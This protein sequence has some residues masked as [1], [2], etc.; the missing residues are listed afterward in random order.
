MKRQNVDANFWLQMHHTISCS[1]KLHKTKHNRFEWIWKIH[2]I[3]QQKFPIHSTPID[4]IQ[5]LWI[6]SFSSFKH[7]Y[8]RLVH[9]FILIWMKWCHRLNVQLNKEWTWTIQK[10]ICNSGSNIY[11][12]S[13]LPASKLYI[14]SRYYRYY[15]RPCEYFTTTVLL[16]KIV[17]K[18]AKKWKNSKSMNDYLVWS[19]RQ[20]YEFISQYPMRLTQY[21]FDKFTNMCWILY[22]APKMQRQMLEWKK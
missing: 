17:H 15:G 21:D 6:W 8:F 2:L 14:P 3:L 10:P 12:E 9:N 5:A 1:R 4:Y 11:S 19:L 13:V 16:K 7:R 22:H 20:H 18:I